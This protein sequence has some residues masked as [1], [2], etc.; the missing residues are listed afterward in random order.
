VLWPLLL[1]LFGLLWCVMYLLLIVLIF[2]L[3]FPTNRSDT[4][5]IMLNTINI[6]CN[7]RGALM[8]LILLLLN[9]PILLL[10]TQSLIKLVWT[11]VSLCA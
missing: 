7:T 2:Y 1:A 10:N 4:L 5:S 11:N 8:C 3:A 6:T 9:P